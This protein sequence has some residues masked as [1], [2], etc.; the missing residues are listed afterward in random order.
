MKSIALAAVLF[1][2][3]VGPA[4]AGFNDGVAAY[5]RGDYEAAYQV[6][7]P[8]AWQGHATAQ[9]NLGFMYDLGQGVR[10][11]HAEAVYARF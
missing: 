10:Q 8:L 4:R 9:G 6:W 11:D 7:L 2:M 3:F 5:N 1:V